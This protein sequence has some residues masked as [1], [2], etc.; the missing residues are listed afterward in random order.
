MAEWPHANDNE[1]PLSRL[2]L[3]VFWAVVIG[4]TLAGYWVLGSAIGDA[5]GAE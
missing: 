3:V 1:R 2:T 4:A 5:L